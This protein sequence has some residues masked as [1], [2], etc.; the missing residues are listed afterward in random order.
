LK[1]LFLIDD[2]FLYFF[3]A[4]VKK[5]LAKNDLVANEEISFPKANQRSSLY[6]PGNSEIITITREELTRFQLSHLGIYC[7]S[8]KSHT[9]LTHS[10]IV[11]LFLL[12]LK[13]FMVKVIV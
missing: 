12:L 13:K 5:T 2:S 9:P 6:C 3:V 1:R 7:I 8:R 11:S 10:G 4:T